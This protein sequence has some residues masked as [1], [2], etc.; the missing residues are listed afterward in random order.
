MSGTVAGVAQVVY[1]E[2]QSRG[3]AAAVGGVVRLVPRM[4]LRPIIHVSEATQLALTG[5]RNELVP[6]A[7]KEDNAKYNPLRSPDECSACSKKCMQ[8]YLLLPLVMQLSTCSAQT[9][10]TA[11]MTLCSIYSASG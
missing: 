6:S 3:V 5:M 4:V 9:W 1:T 8:H 2:H 11:C 7:R 10:Y